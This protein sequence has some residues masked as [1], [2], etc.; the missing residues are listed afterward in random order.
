MRLWVGDCTSRLVLVIL[1][2]YAKPDGRG[3]YPSV[4]TVSRVARVS[5]RCVRQHLKRLREDGVIRRGDQGLVSHARAD[6]RPV[7]WD[8]C[9]RP[10]GESGMPVTQ[11]RAISAAIPEDGMNGTAPRTLDQSQEPSDSN[12]SRTISDHGVNG[13]APPCQATV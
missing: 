3:A 13:T 10:V 5:E 4:R 11:E 1:A 8:L 12:D 6:R 9:M 7:V 2:D